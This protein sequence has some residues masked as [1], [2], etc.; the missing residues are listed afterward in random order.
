MLYSID[1]N[2]IPKQRLF[3]PFNIQFEIEGEKM[4]ELTTEELSLWGKKAV[5]DDQELWLPLACLVHWEE[6]EESHK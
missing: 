4:G 1:F 3:E 6:V 5:R 2:F